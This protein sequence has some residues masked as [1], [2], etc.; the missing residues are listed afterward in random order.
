[1]SKFFR[2][3]KIAK[4]EEKK[5]EPPKSKFSFFP[6]SRLNSD[7][8]PDLE[9][10]STSSSQSISFKNLVNKQIKVID[11]QAKKHLNYGRSIPLAIV[12]FIIAGCLFTISGFMAEF[13]LIVPQKFAMVFTL[14][15][16]NFLTSLMFLSGPYSFGKKLLRKKRIVFTLSYIGSLFFTLFFS[17]LHKSMVMMMICCIWQVV[18]LIFFAFSTIPGGSFTIKLICRMGIRFFDKCVRNVLR[19]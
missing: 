2:A 13:I 5:A 16:I 19:L 10:S 1:M 18:A 6:F 3:I 7:P 12:F 11:T 9:K 8:K 17:T 14:G 15:S 4:E